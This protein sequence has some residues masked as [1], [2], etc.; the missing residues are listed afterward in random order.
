[1]AKT[2]CTLFLGLPN[3]DAITCPTSL[4]T[5]LIKTVA[6]YGTMSARDAVTGA[7]PIQS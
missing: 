2:R 4:G 1:M 5:I 3:F 6:E 7:S